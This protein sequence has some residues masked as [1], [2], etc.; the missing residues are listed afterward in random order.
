MNSNHKKQNPKKQPDYQ[1]MKTIKKGANTMKLI[2]KAK[3]SFN[4]VL[5]QN[6]IQVDDNVRDK[7]KVHEQ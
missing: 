2:K 1:N 6:M 7:V 3:C 4:N 5:V